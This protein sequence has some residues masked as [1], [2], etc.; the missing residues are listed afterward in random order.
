MNEQ[1]TKEIEYFLKIYDL[2]PKLYIAYDRIAYFEK[3]N[4][5]LRISFDINIRSRR[6]DLALENGDFG[7]NLLPEDVYLMEIKTSLSIPLWLSH[8][9]ND[10]SLKK[11]SFSKYGTEYKNECKRG[12]KNEQ[13]I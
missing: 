6:N 4:H 2:F 12:K 5:D 13:F 8:L 1:V 3:D 9:L 7:K 10:F 11:Q